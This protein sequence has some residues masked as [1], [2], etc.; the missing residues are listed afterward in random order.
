[1]FFFGYLINFMPLT[2]SSVNFFGHISRAQSKIPDASGFFDY[3]INF[4][5]LPMSSVIFLGVHIKG[6]K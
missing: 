1:M 2:M 5:P 3:L 6:T 4:M